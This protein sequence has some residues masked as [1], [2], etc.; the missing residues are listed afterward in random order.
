MPIPRWT[1][2]KYEMTKGDRR[3]SWE[4]TKARRVKRMGKR[5]GRE[6][7]LKLSRHEKGIVF[8]GHAADFSMFAALSKK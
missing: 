7:K 1:E 5:C 8:T 2:G 6:E 4:K 3:N